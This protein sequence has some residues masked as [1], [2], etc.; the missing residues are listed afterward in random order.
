M[1]ATTATIRML[2]LNE[3]GDCFLVS[4]ETEGK[5]S[6]LLIDCGSFRNG[7]PSIKRL[8]TVTAFIGEQLNGAPLDVVV[9]THQHNDHVS[10]FCHCQAEFKKL[11]VGQVWLSWL[12]NPRDRLARDIGEKF[13][14]ITRRLA[15]AR[16]ATKGLKGLNIQTKEALGRVEDMLGFFGISAGGEAPQVPAKGVAALKKLGKQD[17]Q[18]LKPGRSLD[19][20]GQPPGSVR[21]HVLGPPR[22]E[23]LLYRKNPRSGE[24]YDHNLAVASMQAAKFLDAVVG[25]PEDVDIEEENYPFNLHFKFLGSKDSTALKRL[26]RSY[27]AD[28]LRKIDYDWLQQAE[29]LALY[30]DTYTNNSSLVLAIELVESGKVLLFAADAQ[31]GNW[32]SWNEVK[33]EDRNVSTD[34]L[35]ARTVF[36]KVGHHASHNATLVETFEKMTHP[37]LVAFIPV[38]KQDPNI[39]KAGG[40]KMPA[41][42]L[43][44][45]LKEKTSGRVLQMDNVNPPDCDPSKEPAKSAWKRV[46]I[47]PT[48]TKDSIEITL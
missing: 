17:P 42:K 44:D 27:G 16:D 33:W 2:R 4:F 15:L 19:M 5:T 22:D 21:V 11:K 3:L 45:R 8:Q 24:S 13:Q 46:K 28:A 34:D 43:F 6:H 26:Q 36:Y 47:A 14:N 38:H 39:R 29:A 37:D 41:K 20:P 40:W 18:Y 32:R 10:G 30:L 7:A 25:E 12:D 1:S 48:I 9:A 31:I 23:E 35:L